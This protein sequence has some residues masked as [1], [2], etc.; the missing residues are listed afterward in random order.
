MKI[1]IYGVNKFKL[2]KETTPKLEA[3]AIKMILFGRQ[4]GKD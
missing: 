2:A 4:M 1:S 3:K